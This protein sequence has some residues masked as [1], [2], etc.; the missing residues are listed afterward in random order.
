MSLSVRTSA[1]ESTADPD[2]ELLISAGGYAYH[3]LDLATI[4]DPAAHPAVQRCASMETAA[5]NPQSDFAEYVGKCSFLL[6]AICEADD[7]A[8]AFIALTVWQQDGRAVVVG[9][10]AMVHPDHRGAGLSSRAGW[11]AIQGLVALLSRLGL[12]QAYGVVL[13]CSPVLMDMLWRYRSALSPNSFGTQEALAPVAYSYL[14][15]FGYRPLTA[16][17]P[18]FVAGAFPGCTK[19][20]RDR[21]DFPAIDALLPAEFDYNTRGDSLLFVCDVKL[22]G[23]APF[24]TM[25]LRQW[26]TPEQIARVDLSP[27][28]AAL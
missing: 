18:W 23:I 9:E 26:C 24:A 7:T 12:H 28:R 1:Q 14:E 22:A 8:A 11:L 6:Y 19:Q 27:R 16:G 2:A 17:A 25:M 15:R 13:T 4:A 10:E 3:V 20:A 21:K 5:W